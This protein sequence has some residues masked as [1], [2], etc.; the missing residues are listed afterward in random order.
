[1]LPLRAVKSTG[2]PLNISTGPLDEAPT[3]AAKVFVGQAGQGYG[4]PVGP[5]PA[6]DTRKLEPF[7]PAIPAVEIDPSGS[8]KGVC[9]DS[10]P[11]AWK[12][13]LCRTES[14]VENM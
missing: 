1:M 12:Y 2:I 6:P 13:S 5:E 14:P 3:G 8:T 9:I 7:D 10:A 4:P 11:N